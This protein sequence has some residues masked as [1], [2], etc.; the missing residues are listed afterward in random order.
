MPHDDSARRPSQ[1][2]ASPPKPSSHAFI[3]CEAWLDFHC[4]L[5]DVV[6]DLAVRV[7]HVDPGVIRLVG[8]RSLPLVA[9]VDQCLDRPREDW[10]TLIERYLH[11]MVDL[12]GVTDCDAR[13]PTS[14]IELRV[15]LV[16]ATPID[17]PVLDSIGAR[18]VTNDL[19]AVLASVADGVLTTVTADEIADLGWDL[20][21]TW[22][23]AWAQTALLEEPDEL[24]VVDLAGVEVVHLFGSSEFTA[25]LVCSL[26]DH[27]GPLGQ[28]GAIIAVPCDHTVLIHPIEGETSRRA[29]GTLVPIVRRI[30]AD[31]PGSLSPQIYWWRDGSLVWIPTVFGGETN[32]VYLPAGLGDALS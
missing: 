24:D 28:H 32:E 15:R 22:A 17:R 1:T 21:E 29:I 20:D 2:P 19:A 26:E 4:E 10:H 3:S 31:G 8:G 14:S 11:G 6:A 18:M 9:L 16:P 12:L 27:V 13:P 30:H 23:S 25:T 7:D 5:Y